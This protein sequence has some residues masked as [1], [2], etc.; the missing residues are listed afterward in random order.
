MK[1]RK[2]VPLK[3]LTFATEHSLLIALVVYSTGFV[4]WNQYLSH[5]GYFEYSFVQ[6]RYLSAGLLFWIPT[7][8]VFG[9]DFL[10]LKFIPLRF[11]KIRTVVDNL[12]LGIISVWAVLLFFFLFPSIPQSLGGARP[13]S[14][15]ILGSPEEIEYLINFEIKP[16]SNAGD[17]PS[18]QTRP[19]CLI[20][21]NS[22]Y[23]LFFNATQLSN[24][25]TEQGGVVSFSQRSILLSNHQFRG[26]QKNDG[27]GPDLV[28]GLS[29]IP[30]N[31]TG[32]FVSPTN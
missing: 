5:Y 21:Q 31:G 29:T 19:I 7:V 8:A 24:A 27:E 28:C 32:R 22:E 6:T 4:L 25:T 26:L 23:I 17:K 16:A 30:F 3:V 9:A 11:N 15:S 10:T 2:K 13:M 18:V 20:Y 12:F 14:M 1:E